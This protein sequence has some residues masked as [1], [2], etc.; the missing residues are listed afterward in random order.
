MQPITY[1]PIGIIHTPFKKPEGTP[2]QPSA[3][4]TIKAE[5]E[6]FQKYS[7]GL[8]DLEGFSNIILL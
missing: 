2:I 5:I 6:I 8:A 7:D 1:H 4:K 3:A